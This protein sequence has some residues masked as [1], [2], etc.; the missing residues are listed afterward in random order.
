M[1]DGPGSAAS[2]FAPTIRKRMD[3]HVKFI[4]RLLH[5]EKMAALCREVGISRKTGYIGKL[6]Q[7]LT[8]GAKTQKAQLGFNSNESL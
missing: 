5:G 2:A 8:T 6:L 3:E 4:A 1:F 7:D